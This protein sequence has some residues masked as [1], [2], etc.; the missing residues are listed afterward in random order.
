MK[1]YL[2]IKHVQGKPMTLG[3]YN[4][5]RG[6]PIPDNEDPERAG[7]LV[8]YPP[9]EGEARNHPDHEGYISWSPKE[10]F[11]DSHIDLSD[12]NASTKVLLNMAPYLF[13]TGPASWGVYR[14]ALVGET[15]CWRAA[16]S[17]MSDFLHSDEFHTLDSAE[18]ENVRAHLA[19]LTSLQEI[20]EARMKAASA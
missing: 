10:A 18:K 3:E 12:R 19:L 8:E 7:Y 11:D 9:R 15:V 17:I 6:W 13:T 2:G 1:Q 4:L 16:A 20:L 14:S 5:Y